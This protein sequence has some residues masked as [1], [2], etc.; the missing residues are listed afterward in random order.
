M[1]DLTRGRPRCHQTVMRR[2]LLLWLAA[3]SGCATARPVITRAD[4]LAQLKVPGDTSQR[5]TRLVTWLKGWMPWVATDYHQRTVDQILAR[6]AGNCADHARVLQSL[7]EENG[8]RTRWVKEINLQPPSRSRLES[9]RRLVEKR[10][11]TASVFGLQHNDHRWLEV[12]NQEEQDWF[13]ADSALG[14]TGRHAWVE[15][16]LGFGPRPEPAKDMLLPFV[17]VAAMPGQASADRSRAYLVEAFDAAYQGRLGHLPSWPAWA[18]QV[19]AMAKLG[20]AAFRGETNLHG[21]DAEM[22]RLGETYARLKAEA[23]ADQS[24]RSIGRSDSV[25]TISGG[26]HVR[27][28]PRIRSGTC[29]TRPD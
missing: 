22:T 17:V 28:L 23:L 24:R 26:I 8:I 7:L 1:I 9:A 20:L 10:G 5:V 14:I 21:H 2:C 6:G 11:V 25:F 13:P 19:L 29:S 15:A 3:L 4:A 18:E 27:L 12:W 16:R